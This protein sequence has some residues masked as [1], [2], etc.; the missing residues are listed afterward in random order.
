MKCFGLTGGVA[1]GKSTAVEIIKRLYPSV[2]LF[3]ADRC[4][5]EIYRKREVLDQLQMIFGEQVIG[6][7]LQL[8]KSLVRDIVFADAEKK[9]DLEDYIHPLVRKECLALRDES[10]QASAASLFIADIPLLFEGDFDFGQKANLVVAVSQET[11]I[12]RL[13]MR[14]G[15]DDATVHAILAAQLPISHKVKCAGVVLWNE[16]T[17]TVLEAQIKRFIQKEIS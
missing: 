3:D 5:H 11:Q 9:R 14:S 15:F 17:I 4:V 1:T 12:R 8:N 10:L 16:G 6:K 13:K 2:V 7:D